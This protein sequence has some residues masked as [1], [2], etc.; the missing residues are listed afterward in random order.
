MVSA[1]GH[2]CWNAISKHVEEKEAF[3]TIIIGLAVLLYLPLA[4]YMWTHQSIP[5]RAFL[6]MAGSTICELV[7]FW[8]LARAYRQLPFSYAFPI[9]RGMGPLVSTFVSFFLGVSLTWI[10]Y[11]GILS[12]VGGIL[13]LQFSGRFSL[14]NGAMWA[15]LAGAFNGGAIT[16][17]S[18]G[19]GLMSGVLFKYLV[20]IGMLLGKLMMDR[21]SIFEYKRV[22]LSNKYKAVIGALFVF[23]ANAVTQYA[24]ESTPVGYVSATRE[25]SIAFGVLIGWL[26]FKEKLRVNHYWGIVLL[27]AGI[28]MIKFGG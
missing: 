12:V 7:Y 28:F 3:F 21:I 24:L 9:V 14:Q 5:N 26:F 13:L 16:F 6:Y 25:L 19:A 18:L 11:G 10:G 15:F 27:I 2:A 17:D 23:G 20:F 4:V 1:L 8:S 22:F